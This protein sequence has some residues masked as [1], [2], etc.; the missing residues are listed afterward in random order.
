MKTIYRIN[1]ITPKSLTETVG[2]S[3]SSRNESFKGQ[4]FTN[5]LLT[6]ENHELCLIWVQQEIVLKAPVWIHSRSSM[7]LSSEARD[8]T[9][10]KERILLSHQHYTRLSTQLT[11]GCLHRY[12]LV[13]CFVIPVAQ[14]VILVAH[15]YGLKTVS[16]FVSWP[17]FF[18]DFKNQW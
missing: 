5:H 4:R 14:D 7:I 6:A 10:V 17:K 9:T 13:A 15:I 12:T 3:S 16:T 2:K 1:N 18:T 11:V 8:S